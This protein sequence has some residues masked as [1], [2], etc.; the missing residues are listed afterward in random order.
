LVFIVENYN[1]L[2]NRGERQHYLL[3]LNCNLFTMRQ[4]RNTMSDQNNEFLS[5]WNASCTTDPRHV[6]SFS[7]GGGFSGTAINHTYQL[8]K[9][10]EMWGPMGGMWGVHIIEQGLMNGAPIIVEDVNEEWTLDEKGERVLTKSIVH[11]HSVANE[12]VHFVR[13][14]LNYP[15]FAKNDSGQDVHIRQGE[16]EHFGQTT[17]VGKNKNGY[18]TD[19]EAPKKS[20]TDA[21]GK[22][23]S[24]LGFSADIYLGLFDDNKYVNDRKAEAAKAGAP[25]AEIKAKM[26]AE[27]VDALKRR[28]SECKSKDTLRGQFA[29]LSE[30][31][32]AV[33]EEFCKALAKGLE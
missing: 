29:L 6:K 23:L 17:F 19:E 3:D 30:D 25:K 13:I 16:V 12:S 5:V 8:R 18:F 31:E 9:A 26:T 20:L 21:I 32:K 1:T 28:L 4:Q 24:M 14:K 11:K 15:V 33:T 10:T 27:Q 22:A 2:Y 7:R